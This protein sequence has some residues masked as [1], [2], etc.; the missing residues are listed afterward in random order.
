[1]YYNSIIHFT[2]LDKIEQL[3]NHESVEI[4]K[5]AFD[6]IERY[7]SEVYIFLTNHYDLC[8]VII[9]FLFFRNLFHQHNLQLVLNSI[10]LTQILSLNFSFFY[11]NYYKFFYC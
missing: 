10:R 8:F 4:Y 11:E 1:M 7:F 3:Q 5:V 2:G 6:I 9:F